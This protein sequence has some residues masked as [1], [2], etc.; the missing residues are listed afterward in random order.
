MKKSIAPAITAAAITATAATTA[1]ALAA[2]VASAAIAADNKSLVTF[3]KALETFAKASGTFR[4]KTLA[5]VD[6]LRKEGFSDSVIKAA[7]RELLKAHPVVTPQ[8]LNRLLAEVMG[9]ERDRKGSPD[10]SVKGGEG[11]AKP[12][13]PSKAAA[14][15]ASVEIKIGDAESL[16]AALLVKFDGDALQIM[17]VAEKLMSLSMESLRK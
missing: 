15:P 7:M 3:S 12:A 14:P 9:N 6:A 13:K 4:D 10:K 8:T 1:P 11:E 5:T 16:F 2:T 17:G